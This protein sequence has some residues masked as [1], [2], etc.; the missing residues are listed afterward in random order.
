MHTL[1]ALIAMTCTVIAIEGAVVIQETPQKFEFGT[2][3]EMCINLASPVMMRLVKREGYLV[4]N[5]Y[6]PN[7]GSGDEIWSYVQ[8][9]PTPPSKNGGAYGGY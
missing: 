8:Q 6:S 9:V 1:Q 2:I 7:P 4:D 5:R 3:F